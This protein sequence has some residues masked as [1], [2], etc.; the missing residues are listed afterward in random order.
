[1]NTVSVTETLE[2]ELPSSLGW[3]T[4]IRVSVIQT[5]EESEGHP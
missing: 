2:I 3:T 1:M 4:E 5:R